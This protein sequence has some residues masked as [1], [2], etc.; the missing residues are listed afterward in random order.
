MAISKQVQ[1]IAA[2]I[3]TLDQARYFSAMGVHWLGFDARIISAL[4]IRGITE[5]VVGP[6]IF[7]ETDLTDADALFK[8]TSQCTFHG[9]CLPQGISPPDSFTGKM[10]QRISIQQFIHETSDSDAI[11]VFPVSEDDVMDQRVQVLCNTRICWVEIPY[12]ITKVRHVLGKISPH[13]FVIRFSGNAVDF[14]HYDR[15]FDILSIL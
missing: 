3:T 12:E 15:I 13:G 9:I 10:I 14:E 7:V 1:W 6:Q 2:G 5:W 8:L 4:E 11:P